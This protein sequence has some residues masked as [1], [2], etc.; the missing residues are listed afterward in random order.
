MQSM[1]T[2][3][4]ALVAPVPPQESAAKP[5]PEIVVTGTR[6][7]DSKKALDA[8][9]ARR[10]PPKEDIAAT[11]AHAENLFVAGKYENAQ[12]TAAAGI[13]RN[14]GFA[15]KLPREVASLF[16]AHARLSAHLG[17][18]ALERSSTI[19]MVSS[20]RAG[21]GNDNPD[22]LVGQIELADVYAKVFNVRIAENNYR[23]IEK[24]ALAIGNRKVEGYA[25]FRR[26]ILLASLAKPDYAYTFR[27]RQVFREL[28]DSPV[29]EHAAFAA[30]ARQ[31][32]ERMSMRGA[33]PER[34][35]Q[36]LASIR[37]AP[38]TARPTLLYGEPV[39]LNNARTA[40]NAQSEGAVMSGTSMMSA[41][42]I[43]DQW[44]DV[45]FYIDANGLP[46]EIETIRTSDHYSGDWAKAVAKSIAT[47]RYAPLTI[48]N[49]EPGVFRVERYT[50]TASMQV[51][52]GSRLATRSPIARIEM[53]D[54]SVEPT[55]SAGTGSANVPRPIV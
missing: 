23:E 25:R 4:L 12:N 3:L 35:N 43:E 44:I 16:R 28:A 27:A 13:R 29:P 39:D 22:V 52:T 10:C 9:I 51:M 49:G 8:C 14:R 33:S 7:S 17:E 1:L 15:A 26:G 40:T 11:L 53:T 36:M 55:A 32:L 41:D 50:K 19:D 38:P 20:L 24:A 46:Q 2:A 42:L 21:L 5:A 47:R 34:I 54:L 45:A 6:L 30:A 37:S 48:V 18:V 31:G